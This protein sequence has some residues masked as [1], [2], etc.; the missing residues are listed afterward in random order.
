MITVNRFSDLLVSFAYEAEN[1]ELLT[2]LKLQKLLYY[3]QGTFM[4]EKGEPLF[5]EDLQAWGLGPV[6][7]AMYHRYKGYDRN[8]IGIETLERGPRI[9]VRYYDHVEQVMRVFGKFSASHLVSLSHKDR[10]WLDCYDKYRP[11]NVIEKSAIAKFFKDHYLF[12][13]DTR[14]VDPVDY[15]DEFAKKLYGAIDAADASKSMSADELLSSL[16]IQ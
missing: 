5:D 16:N 3:A 14:A 8:P 9:D 6:Q 13:E 1:T 11:V 2:N 7:P 15:S 4:R 12:D 10:P